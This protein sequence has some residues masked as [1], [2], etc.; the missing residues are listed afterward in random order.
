MAM[1]T[2]TKMALGG[3]GV[4]ILVFCAWWFVIRKHSLV[5]SFTADATTPPATAATGG[6]PT[7]SL[8]TLQFLNIHQ[9]TNFEFVQPQAE[10]ADERFEKA[11]RRLPQHSLVSGVYTDQQRRRLQDKISRR[12]FCTRKSRSWRTE[13]SDQL[14]GDVR[15]VHKNNWNIMRPQRANYDIDLHSGA[16]GTVSGHG[17]WDS[18]I[19]VPDN[20]FDD[21]ALPDS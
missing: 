6:L 10:L 15:P 16:L 20:F 17:K 11:K 14:R 19:Q 5:E 8:A 7:D 21:V 12:P 2:K 4:A 9:A 18:D 3:V 13:F 1:E